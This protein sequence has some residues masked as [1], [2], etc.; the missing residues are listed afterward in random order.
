MRAS[1]IVVIHAGAHHLDDSLGSLARYADRAD[2]EVV[3]V[4]NASADRC[5]EEARQ[6]FPWARVVRSDHNVGFAG[7]VHLGAEAARGEVLVLLNDDAAAREGLVERH[8]ETLAAHPGAAVSAGRLVRW[9]GERHDFLRGGVT[10]D[11]HAFQLG[12]DVPVSEIDPPAEGEALPFACGGN[13]AIRRE[14]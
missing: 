8:L 13:M 5:G 2:V 1:V 11:C 9:D 10:F 14:E 4:D 12:Q 3:L 6:R 7:G